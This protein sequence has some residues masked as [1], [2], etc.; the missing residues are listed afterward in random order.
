[1]GYYIYHKRGRSREEEG[2]PNRAV[3]DKK[4]KPPSPKACRCKTRLA[5]TTKCLQISKVF[6]DASRSLRVYDDV[7]PLPLDVYFMA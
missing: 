4:K 6:R 3:A 2:Y 7:S 1:V 5:I